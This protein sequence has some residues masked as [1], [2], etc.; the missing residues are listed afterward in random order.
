MT[1]ENRIEIDVLRLRRLVRYCGLVLTIGIVS[2]CGPKGLERVILTGDVSHNGQPIPHGIIRFTPSTST[3]G[4][5]VA[6][7]IEN[8]KY[9]VDSRGGVPVG[10]HS[11]QIEAYRIVPRSESRPGVPPPPNAVAPAGDRIQWLP[12]KY[13][14]E[15]ELTVTIEPD[16]LD[17][18][19][20]FALTD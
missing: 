4:S 17:F 3:L 19:R 11:V 7:T 2:G 18:V 13:N 5:T 14:D 9:K 6:A 8:G 15:T 16:S 12:P 1:T 20:D 10:T